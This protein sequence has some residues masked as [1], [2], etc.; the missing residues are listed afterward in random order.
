[1]FGSYDPPVVAPTTQSKFESLQS[2]REDVFQDLV[3]I[4]Y[5]FTVSIEFLYV[6]TFYR[7][8]D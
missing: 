1:M 2:R 3:L 7:Q 4:L 5:M 8:H 6:L